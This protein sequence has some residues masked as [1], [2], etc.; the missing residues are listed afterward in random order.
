M[1]MKE[2]VCAYKYFPYSYKSVEVIGVSGGSILSVAHLK[3]AS[4]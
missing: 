2:C 1:R 4:S 3:S